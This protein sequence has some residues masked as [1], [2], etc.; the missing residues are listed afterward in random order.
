MG[1]GGSRLGSGRKKGV[2][3]KPV[4]VPES[5]SFFV[6]VLSQTVKQRPDDFMHLYDS[7]SALYMMACL[8]SADPLKIAKA[9]SRHKKRAKK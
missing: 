6:H 9:S 1:S 8:S 3:T 2:K 4:R 5:I 7:N